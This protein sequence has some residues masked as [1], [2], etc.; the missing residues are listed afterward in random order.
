MKCGRDPATMH[1][2]CPNGIEQ[3][4]RWTKPL[5]DQFVIFECNTESTPVPN[6]HS[7]LVSRYLNAVTVNEQDIHSYFGQPHAFPSIHNVVSNG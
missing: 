5:N 1:T 2:S 3:L 7:L 4:P 6:M